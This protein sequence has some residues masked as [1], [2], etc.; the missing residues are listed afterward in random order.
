MI[1]NSCL[2]LKTNQSDVVQDD[3]PHVPLQ[4]HQGWVSDETKLL[5]FDFV[6]HSTT[7]YIILYYV[8]NLWS[9]SEILKNN[10]FFIIMSS[11]FGFGV[12]MCV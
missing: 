4:R 8:L 7:N 5:Y 6:N 9:I 3:M 2:N 11:V 10:V 1:G 12:C